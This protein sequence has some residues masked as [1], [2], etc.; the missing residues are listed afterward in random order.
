MIN[1]K[2]NPA[3]KTRRLLKED[4]VIGSRLRKMRNLLCRSQ[5]DVAQSIGITFQQLQKYERAQNRVSAGRLCQLAQAYDCPVVWF[6][7]DYAN[8][9]ANPL[10][11]VELDFLCLFRSCSLENQQ[12]IL[13]L[14]KACRSPA[15][16]KQNNR[17]PLD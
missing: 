6:F 13:Q 14:L 11:D 9:E 16:L 8:A 3:K 15:A 4:V 10:S 17:L 1:T 5:Y 2:T 12:M 7:G